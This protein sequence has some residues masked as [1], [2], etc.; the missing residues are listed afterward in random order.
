MTSTDTEMLARR[1]PLAGTNNV[2][3]IGGYVTK[4][5]RVVAHH[6]V[7][8]GDVLNLVDD[9]GRELLA[10]IGLR[11]SIDLRE[12]DERLAAPDRLNADVELISIPLLTHKLTSSDDTIEHQKL[13]TLDETYQFIVTTRGRAIADV[14]SE[15]ARP[16]TLPAL[17]HCTAGKDRTGIV[18]A[19]LLSILDV[20]DE[21]IAHDYHA[22]GVFMA[23]FHEAILRHASE[24]GQDP[25]AYAAMQGCEP[26]L[27]LDV[28]AA[29]RSSHGDVESYLIAHG[30][31][32]ENIERLRATLLEG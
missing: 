17:V 5:G 1:I 29:V 22:T 27:I 6:R 24:T 23:E 28:L 15:L 19:L 14:L 26:Y 32:F 18:I 9:Q 30:L 20:P 31:T 7:L 13:T 16:E 2:R 4:D 12:S 10:Q 8:R 11:T 25:F 21:I 3:D